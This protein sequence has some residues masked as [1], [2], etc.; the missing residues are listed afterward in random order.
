MRYLLILPL[1]LAVT[2]TCGQ[3]LSAKQMMGALTYSVEA[4]DSLMLHNGFEKKDKHKY[5]DNG[6]IQHYYCSN[7]SYK[8]RSDFYGRS[9]IFFN[10]NGKSVIS[11]GFVTYSKHAYKKTVRSFKRAS[12]ELVSKYTKGSTTGGKWAK[13]KHPSKPLRL[14]T[15][16]Y[17]IKEKRKYKSGNYSVWLSIADNN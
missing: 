13:Y 14:A 6:T 9:T 3:T 5:D 1:L 15:D 12:F 16:D 11:I 17:V 8:L 2:A 7:K 10:T 4:F